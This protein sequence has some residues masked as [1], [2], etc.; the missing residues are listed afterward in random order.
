VENL[1]GT[2][3]ANLAMT[4]NNQN[5][6]IRT[7]AGNDALNG[8]AGDDTLIGGAGNDFYLVDSAG[9]VVV[10][11][12]GEGASDIVRTGIASY[13]LA[14]NVE[15]LF[16]TNAAGQTLTGNALDNVITGAG[17]AD[18]LMGGSGADTLTGGTGADV[19]VY[20][21]VTDSTATATDRIVGFDAAAGDRVDLTP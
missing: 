13:T 11:L 10:E 9:D 1:T 18:R 17:G 7:G 19:F 4:G 15:R 14:D 5:N 21:L 6:V 16:G 20:T 8:Q 12:A 2:S 3:N